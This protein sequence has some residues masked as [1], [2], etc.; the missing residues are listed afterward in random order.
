VLPLVAAWLQVVRRESE[1]PDLWVEVER[2]RATVGEPPPAVENTPFNASEIE[3]IAKQVEE[4]KAYVRH[5]YDLPEGQ[6]HALEARLDYLVE[7]SHR[8][9][10]LDWRNA[11]LGVLLGAIVQGALPSNVVRDVLVMTL[12]GIGALFGHDLP[13]LPTA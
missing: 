3:Q 2:E 10:R 13:Q 12:R 1:A 9:P 8:S 6:L 4:V 5:T 11:M 7:A